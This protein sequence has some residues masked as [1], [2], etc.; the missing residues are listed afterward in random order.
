[1]KYK[2]DL[3]PKL[4]IS[5][6]S[7]TGAPDV[8]KPQP[9][10][11]VAWQPSTWPAAPTA[12]DEKFVLTLKRIFEESILGE[13]ANVI[14]DAQAQNGDLQHRG[15]VV[16]IALLCALDAISSYGYGARSGRQIPQF[17]R[18]HFPVPYRP[19]ADSLLTLYRHAVVHSWNLFEVS[20][21]PGNEQIT[22]SGGILSF[23]L[24]D[25]FEALNLAAGEFLGRLELDASLQKKTLDRYKQLRKTAKA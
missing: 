10:G 12:V 14:S 5:A 15:H 2:L 23:G 13:I 22:K 1:M 3:S 19:R 11:F 9:A 24:L 25:L 21:T 6:P 4:D 8:G 16:A 17:V 20:I 18:A 7:I